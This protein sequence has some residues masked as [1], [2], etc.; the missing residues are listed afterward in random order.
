MKDFKK[1]HKDSEWVAL[2]NYKLSDAEKQLIDKAE[3][4]DE[5]LILLGDIHKKFEIKPS[6]KEKQLLSKVYDSLLDRNDIGK[7]DINLQGAHITIENDK[8]RGVLNLIDS[9]GFKQLSF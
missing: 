4:T 2:V 6:V 3:K 7:E 1:M 8:L 5:E 9:N